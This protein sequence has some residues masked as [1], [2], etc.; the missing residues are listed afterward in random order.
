MQSKYFKLSAI[1]AALMLLCA[2]AFAA[3][4]TI[5][6]FGGQAYTGAPNLT[7]TSALIRAGGGAENFSTATALVNMLGE[8][9]VNA[10]VAKLTKQYSKQKVNNWLAGTDGVIALALKHATAQAISLPEA[11]A[12]LKGATLAKALV[13]AG[14]TPDGTFWSGHF[15]DMLVSHGIHNA[16]MKDVNESQK[17]G[18]AFDKN[19][20]TITNQAFYDVAQALGMNDVQL[21]SLH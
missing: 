19:V 17:M 12:S 2:T 13:K 16:V 10:E 3:T 1:G 11:P 5:N 14:I 21:A 8:K 4:P 18:V 6:M 7:L 20:H 9:T 15:Y